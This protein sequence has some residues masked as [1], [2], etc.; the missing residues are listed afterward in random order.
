MIVTLADSPRAVKSLAR[1]IKIHADMKSDAEARGRSSL[2]LGQGN[3]LFWRRF[4]W[5]REIRRHRLGVDEAKLKVRGQLRR[6]APLDPSGYFKSERSRAALEAGPRVRWHDLL[7]RL[8]GRLAL[9]IDA[10]VISIDA[11]DADRPTGKIEIIVRVIKELEQQPSRKTREAARVKSI[12][13]PRQPAPISIA[14]RSLSQYCPVSAVPKAGS[15]SL[16]PTGM[17]ALGKKARANAHRAPH[18]KILPLGPARLTDAQKDQRQQTANSEC[19]S[20]SSSLQ[21]IVA[22]MSDF[23]E[24][25]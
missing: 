19:V 5:R 3:G 25:C 22:L 18:R 20:H 13:E 24:R 17:S 1:E 12:A 9:A 8:R 23:Q 11:L 16:G 14:S 7:A 2:R 15:I 21:A 10:T 4:P 6:P